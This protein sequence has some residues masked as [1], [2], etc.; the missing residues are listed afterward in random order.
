MDNLINYHGLWGMPW[1]VIGL[2]VGFLT[3]AIL[4]L[5][6]DIMRAKR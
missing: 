4:A 2:G 5:I 1:S 3:S 6:F